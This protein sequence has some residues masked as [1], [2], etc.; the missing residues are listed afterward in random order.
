M[1]NFMG[2]DRSWFEEYGSED[3]HG[4]ALWAV[5]YTIAHPPSDAILGL[6][7]RLFKEI[8]NTPCSF[9]SPRAWAFSAIG[10]NYYLRRFSGD[11]RVLQIMA[12]LAEKIMQ[13]FRQNAAEDW[14][15]L[16][17]IVSYDNGRLPQALIVTSTQLENNDIYEMGIKSLQWLIDIQT[18]P[19]G[20]H[21]SLIGNDGW[22]E[23]G[24]NK[25]RFDQQPVDAAAL[26]DACYQA[27]VSSGDDYWLRKVEWAFNWF[28]GSNDVRQPLYDFSTGACYDGLQPGGINKNQGGESV[29]SLL[30]ALQR[31]HLIAHQGLLQE[32]QQIIVK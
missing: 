14:Y 15:W 13:L 18:N 30:L 23:R 8:I 3:S 17:D 6:A 27:F 10:A 20:G 7:T 29:A 32:Q 1:R 12:E 26:V 25:A 19:E 31:V 22:Y 21:L 24:G 2:Y 11:T 16:E 4:R 5:G 28:F 9:T